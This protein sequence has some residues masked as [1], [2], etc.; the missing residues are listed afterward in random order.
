MRASERAERVYMAMLCRGF[1]GKFHSL[2]EFFPIA[3]GLDLAVLHYH[4][5]IG[6]TNP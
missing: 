1:D 2:S 3:V 6:H 5:P 4:D